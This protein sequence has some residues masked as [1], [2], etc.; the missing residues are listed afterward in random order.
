[1][2]KKLLDGGERSEYAQFMATLEELAG[3]QYL[4]ADKRYVLEELAL[5][6]QSIVPSDGY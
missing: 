6:A 1:V 3:S 5:Y 4:D 2:S